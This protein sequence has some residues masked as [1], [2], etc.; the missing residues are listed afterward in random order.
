M[1]RQLDEISA[2]R[3]MYRVRVEQAEGY[4]DHLLRPL[5]HAPDS[6][7]PP[8]ALAQRTTTEFEGVRDT[9]KAVKEWIRDI[10]EKG[11]RIIEDVKESCQGMDLGHQR[12]RRADH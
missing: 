1:L 7:V 2:N 12:K 9:A 10:K 4:I 11:E 8:L 6:H 5:Q 3:N